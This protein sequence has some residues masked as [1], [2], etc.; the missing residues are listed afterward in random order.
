MNK[1]EDNQII[2]DYEKIKSIKKLSKLYNFS[3]EKTRQLLKKNNVQMVYKNTKNKNN[4]PLAIEDYKKGLSVSK[5]KKKYGFDYNVFKKILELNKLVYINRSKNPI[6]KDMDKI[7]NNKNILF[8]YKK[9]KNLSK[10]A[11]FFNLKECN[12]RKFLE[13]NNILNKKNQKITKQFEN[14][15]KNEVFDLYTIKKLNMSDIAKKFEITRYNVKKIIVNNFGKK[16]IK[17]KKEIIK[18]LN[19]RCEHQKK[20]HDGNFKR[21]TY[22]LPSG[23][24]IKVQGYEDD[25]LNYVFENTLIKEE[26]FE[27]DKR[28]RI[29]L[30]TKNIKYKHYYPDFYIPKYNLVIEIKS[31]YTY[32]LLKKLNDKKIKKTIESGYNVF[33]IKDKNYHSF[34]IFLKEKNLLK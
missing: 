29:C 5:I 16:F 30:S 8:E 26:D 6:N 2:K 25:F 1:F 34:N 11:K 24:Q 7:K 20:A 3:Y 15:I 31:T 13:K 18:E 4:I 22:S 28:L 9:S 23:K 21:K 10:T 12:L 32:N 14:S 17:S 19:Y 27:L 33:M